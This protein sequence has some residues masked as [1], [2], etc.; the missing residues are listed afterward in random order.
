MSLTREQPDRSAPLAERMRPKSLDEFIG[1][2]HLVGRGKFIS[3]CMETG[4]IPSIIFWG[5][6][7]SGKTTLARIIAGSVG[8]HF[9]SFSAVV[10]GIKEIKTLMDEIRESRRI[11]NTSAHFGE[12]NPAKAHRQSS[13]LPG[14]G[15]PVQAHKGPTN[16]FVLFVDEIHRFNKAQ[17]DAFLP[18]VEKGDIV[19]MGATTQNPSFEVI[20]ALL[21]RCKVLVLK[22]LSPEQVIVGLKRALS[23][24]E[25]G[26]VNMKIS[27]DDDALMFIAQGCGGDM[28]VALN[29]LEVAVN[30]AEPATDGTKCISLQNVEE[31]MQRKTPL[32]DKSGEEHYNIISAFIKSMRG[33]DPDAAVYYLARMLEAG[34]DPLFIARRMVIFA[35]EDVGNADPE[36]IRVAISAMQS[37][38]FVGMPEGWIPLAQCATYL[39]SAP[40]SN[41]S[42]LSYLAAKADVEAHGALPVP[43]HIRNAPTKLMKGLGYGKGYQYPHNYE[44]HHV[45]ETYLPEKLK[46]KTYYVPTDIG[47]EKEIKERLSKLKKKS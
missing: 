30:I 24:S 4:E 18:H 14:I 29:T 7:G 26:L 47:R 16:K 46:G 1:Q 10:S 11:A 40:K 27:T 8:A 2:E 39:A 44:E 32:Y 31:A 22:E 3:R 9:K 37:F 23:D 28:R 42:Y 13:L 12:G 20:S 34:E 5:P 35:S 19:L 43:M 15:A 41:A 33:S 36:A 45:E 25:R 21:S 6:P 17:Q 38:D